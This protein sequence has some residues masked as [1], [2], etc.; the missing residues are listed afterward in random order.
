MGY[1]MLFGY[2]GLLSLGH[3]MFFAA[4]LYGAGL[5]V[6]HLRLSACRPP[7]CAALLRRIVLGAGDRPASRCGPAASPS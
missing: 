7:S 1:N 3:A 2:A 6:Y 5:A 4:G